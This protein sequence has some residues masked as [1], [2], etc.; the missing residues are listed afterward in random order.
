MVRLYGDYSRP[1]LQARAPKVTRLHLR[2]HH[3]WLTIKEVGLLS[4]DH[5]P[6]HMS[7]HVAFASASKDSPR[8]CPIARNIEAACQSSLGG[9]FGV[10]L[11]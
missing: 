6:T 3:L 1:Y 8:N 10:A 9:G 5:L 2:T 11:Q 7:T 4:K